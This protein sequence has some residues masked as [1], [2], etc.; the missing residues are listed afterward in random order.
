MTEST[1]S[2]VKLSGEA[3]PKPRLT[4]KLTKG[5]AKAHRSLGAQ[6]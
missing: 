5:E 2:R 1:K 3:D 4:V 6:T